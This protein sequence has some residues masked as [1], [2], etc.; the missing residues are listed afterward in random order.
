MRRVI[1]KVEISMADEFYVEMPQNAQPLHIAEQPDPLRSNPT[2][3]VCLWYSF[4]PNDYQNIH[5]HLFKLATTGNEFNI[6][7]DA[8]YVGTFQLFDGEFVGHLFHL[9]SQGSVFREES[10]I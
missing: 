4:H 5:R 10:R 7:N 2:P 9:G 3:K 8:T 1:H 6:E